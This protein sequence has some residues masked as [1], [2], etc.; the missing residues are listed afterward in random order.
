ML[1]IKRKT[2]LLFKLNKN[3]HNTL[4]IIPVIDI[5]SGVVVHAVK[6]KRTEYKPLKSILSDSADPLAVAKAFKKCG[7]REL[8]VADLDAIMGKGTNSPILRQIAEKTGLELIVDAGTSDLKHAQDL[9]DSKVS[10]VI[11]GTETLLHLRFIN[12]AVDCFGAEKV[13]VSLDLNNGKVLSKSAEL[14]SMGVLG[15]AYELQERGISELIVL[16][17]ARVGSGE[18]VDVALLEEIMRG[19]KVKLLVGGGV[20]DLTDLQNLN[21]IGVYGVL[22]AT[23]LHSGRISVEQL[24]G[25][26]LL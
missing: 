21:E 13:I 4:K 6:G 26:G 25:M 3:R 14:A 11:I 7:F 18:G 5:L 24:H 12:E 23:A 17:L 16:D 19:L 15:L 10:K 9:F 2:S 22:L 1:K 20:C 8:Y